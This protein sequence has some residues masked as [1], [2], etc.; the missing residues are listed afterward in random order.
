MWTILY[1]VIQSNKSKAHDLNWHRSGEGWSCDSVASETQ[2]ILLRWIVKG[3]HV[4]STTW[5]H[6]LGDF[7]RSKVLVKL[8]KANPVL[9]EYGVAAEV[10]V[11][12]IQEP[13]GSESDN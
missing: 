7:H 3:Q 12:K 1:C 13:S 4:N 10:Y 2:W 9:H 11:A 5:L 8:N 6:Y